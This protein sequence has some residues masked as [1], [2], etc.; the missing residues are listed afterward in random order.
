MA[1]FIKKNRRV[2][3]NT[4]CEWKVYDFL[5]SPVF[6]IM[7]ES[8][9]FECK[10]KK[11][12]WWS[13]CLFTLETENRDYLRFYCVSDEILEISHF[14]P[15]IDHIISCNLKHFER[16]NKNHFGWFPPENL[17]EAKIMKIFFENFTFFWL[18]FCDMLGKNKNLLIFFGNFLL[19]AGQ[20]CA[21][22]FFKCVN[23][24]QK[25]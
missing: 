13:Y 7:S 15:V 24:S 18:C 6:P 12:K 8:H 23:A 25:L 17:K 9:F 2:F 1:P 5:K 21:G 22:N 3:T 20:K 4:C 11:E 19:Y 10:L 14:L 16:F